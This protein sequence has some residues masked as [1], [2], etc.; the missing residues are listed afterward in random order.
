M[1]FRL[2]DVADDAFL[3]KKA[4]FKMISRIE[5]NFARESCPINIKSSSILQ[6]M[7]NKRAQRKYNSLLQE[8]QKLDNDKVNAGNTK[9]SEELIITFVDFL[10]ALK[11][12]N[13]L[14]KNFLPDNQ[15]MSK[16][17]VKLSIF[18]IFF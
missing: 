11:T 16:V 14:Y 17:L 9:E 4:I 1:I 6:E 13:D 15:E 3:S 12:K 8:L 18:H 7:A 10:T 2:T 5:R